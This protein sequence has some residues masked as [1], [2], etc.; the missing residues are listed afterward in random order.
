MVRSRPAHPRL[1][2]R[3]RGSGDKRKTVRHERGPKLC[4][5]QATYFGELYL[6]CHDGE[7]ALNI[8]DIEPQ[9]FYAWETANPYVGN[10]LIH[11][12]ILC[13]GARKK[14]LQVVTRFQFHIRPSWPLYKGL[15]D[16]FA[17]AMVIAILPSTRLSTI[18]MTHLGLN[19]EHAS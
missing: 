8:A 13:D 14:D 7:D 5:A 17:F 10:D 6:P 9:L 15:A 11:L 18:P 12:P 4:K 1:V 2:R 16:P 3:V 19:V